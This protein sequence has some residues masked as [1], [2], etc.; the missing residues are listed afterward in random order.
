MTLLGALVAEDS[1]W[2]CLKLGSA[3]EAA[4]GSL[5]PKG[6]F[7]PSPSWAPSRLLGLLLRVAVHFLTGGCRFS[8]RPSGVFDT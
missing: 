1:G 7:L 4:R 5:A 8:G 6:L 2:E 3:L